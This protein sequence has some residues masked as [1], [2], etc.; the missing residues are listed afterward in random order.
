MNI[1]PFEKLAC[2]LDGNNLKR[3][4][5]IWYCADGHTFDIARQGYSNLLLVQNM[6]SRSPGDSKTMVSARTRFLQQG[7]YSPIAK[8]VSTL[9]GDRNEHFPE[10]S[11]LDSGCGDGYY[12]NQI[13]AQ[14]AKHQNLSLIGLDISKWAVKAAAVNNKNTTWIVATNANLPI[15]SQSLDYVLCVFGFPV[16]KEYLRV[17]KTSGQLIRVNTGPNHLRQ[18]RSIIYSNVHDKSKKVRVYPAGFIENSRQNL[19]Y[20]IKLDTKQQI[21][22]LL[23]MTPHLYRANKEGLA[24]AAELNALEVTIDVNLEVFSL[25]TD[26]Y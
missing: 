13:I 7:F 6:R 3:Q 12:L 24:K 4:D 14:N 5:S 20:L 25:A 9:L 23:E 8:A 2:P 22:D 21:S 26:N 16:Y 1:Q 10:I 17:L 18:L 15:Q 19:T 11:C